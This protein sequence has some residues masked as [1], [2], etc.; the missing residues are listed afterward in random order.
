MSLT[1]DKMAVSGC[2]ILWAEDNLVNQRLTVRLLENQ[3]HSV[4]VA[5]DGNEALAALDKEIFDLILMDVQM[6]HLN[7]YEAT[8][9]IREREATAGGHIPIIAM[10]AHALKGDRERCLEAGMDGYLS[11]PIDTKQLLEAVRH[12]A[13]RHDKGW[14]K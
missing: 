11:K 6:P 4:V 1:S 10:T 14:E 2:H 12:S 3:G 7:G 13:A 8:A 9:A 5:G